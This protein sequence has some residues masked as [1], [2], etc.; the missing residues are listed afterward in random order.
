MEWLHVAACAI[1][2]ALPL[3]V[4]NQQQRMHPCLFCVDRCCLRERS[5][6]VPDAWPSWSSLSSLPKGSCRTPISSVTWSASA[7]ERSQVRSPALAYEGLQTNFRRCKIVG[8]QERP[9][10]KYALSAV[11][12][13]PCELR[14]SRGQQTV[15]DLCLAL[16]PICKAATWC[17]RHA[18]SVESRMVLTIAE[19]IRL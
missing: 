5:A 19:F 13:P 8:A 12:I 15:I 10:V 7:P 11:K 2:H 6:P 14:V 18:C 16:S 9:R 17:N 3:A 1:N 4:R